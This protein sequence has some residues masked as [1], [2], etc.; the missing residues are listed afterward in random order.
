MGITSYSGLTLAF[1]RFYKLEDKKE[2]VMGLRDRFCDLQT[3]IEYQLAYLKPWKE[4]C[5]I[6][7]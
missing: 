3:K 7:L 5:I 6:I 1:A 2:N 4:N